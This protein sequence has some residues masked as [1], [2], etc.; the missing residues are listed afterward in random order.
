MLATSH[1]DVSLTDPGV[2]R[3]VSSAG[4]YLWVVAVVGYGAGAL[5]RHTAGAIAVMFCVRCA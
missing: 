3:A 1:L 2:L 5:M 4:L